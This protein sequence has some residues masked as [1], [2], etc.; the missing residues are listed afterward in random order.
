MSK[1]LLGILTLK[2]ETNNLPLNFR[3]QLSRDVV[4]HPRRTETYAKKNFTE[5]SC[6]RS[7][8]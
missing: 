5:G 2:D 3:K 8:T 1:I 6:G 7:K 4:S